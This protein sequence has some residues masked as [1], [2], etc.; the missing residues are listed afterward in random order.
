MNLN[1]LVDPRAVL[2]S[3]SYGR[4]YEENFDGIA[5][6]R[7]DA[8]RIPGVAS[9]P[10]DPSKHPVPTEEEP[11]WKLVLDFYKG[12]EEDGEDDDGGV[13]E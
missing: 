1:Y 10:F 6:S 8:L 3:R 7:A 12:A 2:F 5:P 4:L 11:W 9:I 13:E